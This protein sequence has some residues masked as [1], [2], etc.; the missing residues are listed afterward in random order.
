[1]RRLRDAL[2]AASR[3][4]AETGRNVGQ[5][6]QTVAFNPNFLMR[7]GQRYCPAATGESRGSSLLEFDS[8]AVPLGRQ[9]TGGNAPGTRGQQSF[10]KKGRNHGI[11]GW[12]LPADAG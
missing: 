7:S 6:V 3:K 12:L 9:P 4:Q 10:V 11:L 5:L 1:M 8:L 2:A